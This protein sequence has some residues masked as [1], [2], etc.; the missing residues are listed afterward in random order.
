[1]MRAFFT[2]VLPSLFAVSPALADDVL[3]RLVD[4]TQLFTLEDRDNKNMRDRLVAEGI[5]ALNYS[6]RI[7]FIDA[8]DLAE[9]FFRD[10][11]TAASP[12]L[13][14]R[15]F[16]LSS[17]EE[18]EAHDGGVSV[19]V[20]GKHYE[21]FSGADL[22]SDDDLIWTKPSLAFWRVV[23]DNLA[24]TSKEKFYLLNSAND[25]AGI[26]LD[27]RLFA[28]WVNS[29]EVKPSDKPYVPNSVGRSPYMP[30]EPS[31]GWRAHETSLKR[32]N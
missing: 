13:E 17:Y 15:G 12:Y 20:N 6:N 29:P 3:L 26:F 31:W 11:L 10:R 25:L 7:F 32:A 27:E 21:L 30:D 9:G 28:Y 14:P 2:S 18:I 8:E 1:M 19:I 22:K 5:G 24:P 23:N 4:Q 16:N